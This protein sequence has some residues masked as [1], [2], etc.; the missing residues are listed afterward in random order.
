MNV[1]TKSI[2]VAMGLLGSLWISISHAQEI[3]SLL[4]NN[5]NESATAVPKKTI[6]VEHTKQNDK[7]IEERLNKI[8]SELD[9]LTGIKASVSNGI[10]TLSG[11]AE[12]TTAENKA[13]QMANQIE[14]I[15]E[16]ENKIVITHNLTKRLQ[17][18]SDKLVDIVGEFIANLP[19]YLLALFIFII[20]WL[21]GS[22]LSKRK[23]LFQRI[24][25]NYFIADLLSLLLY[26]IFVT[27]GLIL[28][29]SL[30][31]ATA[32]MGTILGAAGIFS[33]AIGFAVRDTVENFI[34]SI[35]LSIRNPFEM[36]DLVDIEGIEGR[37]IRLTTRATILISLDGNHIRIPNSTVFKAVIINY[38]HQPERRF[39]FELGIANDEDLSKVQ[40]LIVKTL[41]KI[42]GVLNKPKPQA[43]IDR[44]NDSSVI[45]RVSSWVDQEEHDFHRVRSESI[46]AVRQ[47]IDEANIAMPNPSYEV[48][49][50]RK[51][52][53]VKITEPDEKTDT[54]M[55]VEKINDTS[56]SEEDI[57]LLSD[58]NIETNGENLLNPDGKSEI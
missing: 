48:V 9:E 15:V 41:S 46:K 35:L 39:Q 28:S 14:N 26:I 38:S 25:T 54:G 45:I 52:K 44:M 30:L 4:G 23:T 50:S 58:E 24:A 6:S 47:A 1:C 56:V 3:N 21:T 32:L 42:P 11:E 36:N 33:L 40:A 5:S 13:V 18:T 31:D 12:S 37:V 51:P 49:V 7:K 22:W 20:F 19:T 53:Q 43:L 16:I 2:I 27:I 17:K 57:H 29:L 55:L 8:Y 10:I 34:A